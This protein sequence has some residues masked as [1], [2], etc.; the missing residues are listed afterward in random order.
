L[1]NS[2]P[3]LMRLL[4]RDD[5]QTIVEYGLVLGTLSL[6]LIGVLVVTGLTDDFQTL[7]DKIFPD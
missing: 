1:W 6:V 5:G 4:R 3:S 2:I 7:V